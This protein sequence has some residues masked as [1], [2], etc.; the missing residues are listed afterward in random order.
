VKGE[1]LRYEIRRNGATEPVGI[2]A[3]D[4]CGSTLLMM[5]GH[6]WLY[7][8][9]GRIIAAQNMKRKRD[10]VL[11][12]LGPFVASA[13]AGLGGRRADSGDNLPG[14]LGFSGKVEI[15]WQGLLW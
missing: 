10:G 9:H 8:C 3:T 13:T 15:Y 4:A 14:F 5:T 6:D 11:K 7:A 1:S 12:V 2:E